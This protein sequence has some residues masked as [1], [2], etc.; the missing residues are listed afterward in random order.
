MLP[1]TL[2]HYLLVALLGTFV[3]SSATQEDAAR[4]FFARNGTS[5]HTNNWAVLVCTSRYWFNYRHMANALSMY[6]TIKRL[7]IPDSNII[8][9]LADDASCNARNKFPGAVYANPGKHLDLYGENV[10]VDYRGRVEPSV[11]RSKRLLSDENSNIFI[12]M[13]GHG[14]NDFL[15]FQDNEEISSHDIADAF[16]QMYQKKRYNEIFFMVDTCQANSLYSQLYSP[17]IL[18]TGS[19]KVGE[20][21]YSHSSDKD[22]GVAVID[23]YTHSVLEFLE[24]INKTSHATLQDLFGSIDPAKINSHPGVR[25]DLFQR[26]LDNT[27]ITDFFGGVS[28]VEVADV[29]ADDELEAEPEQQAFIPPHRQDPLLSC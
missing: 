10:E 23:A 9:M 19:S 22:L 27:L 18:A 3:R 17:N 13:T 5:S 12:F 29:A 24:G 7:G 11:S 26:P 21:S 28:Q 8:L 2:F 1:L 20:N 4:Q 15:K 14:G 6:R 16:E 25:S